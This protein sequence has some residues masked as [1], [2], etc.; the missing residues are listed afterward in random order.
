[1]K[2]VESKHGNDTVDAVVDDDKQQ[3]PLC[4]GCGRHDCP[5]CLPALDPPRYCPQC[6]TWLAT[7]VTPAGWIARCRIHGNIG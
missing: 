4:D 2:T 1:M 5:G 3:E 7:H 6:G